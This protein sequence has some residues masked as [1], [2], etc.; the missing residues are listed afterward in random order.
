MRVL[1]GVGV[2]DAS[3]VE[4]SGRAHV[5]AGGAA[6]ALGEVG[7]VVVHDLDLLAA[8]EELGVGVVEV[9]D[10]AQAADWPEEPRSQT[11]GIWAGRGRTSTEA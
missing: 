5:P 11:S 1:S 9:V 7:A 2:D 10:A 4:G 3:L 8:G 6:R